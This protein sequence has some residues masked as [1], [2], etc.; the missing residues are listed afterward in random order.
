LA[1]K[2]WSIQKVKS[3]HITRERER[4]DRKR[5]RERERAGRN[6]IVNCAREVMLLLFSLISYPNLI[7]WM[8]WNTADPQTTKTKRAKSQGPTGYFSSFAFDDLGTFPLNVTFLLAFSLAIRILCL[9]AMVTL[10]ELHEWITQKERKEG[11]ASAQHLG[12]Q[13][14]KQTVPSNCQLK[15]SK[16]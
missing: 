9:G 4:G 13:G 16:C 3:R 12:R 11:E 14:N 10:C 5:E 8:I 1:T 2:D 15:C 7:L 6:T